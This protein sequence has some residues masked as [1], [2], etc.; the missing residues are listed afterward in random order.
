M[1]FEWDPVKDAANRA[2][3]AVGFDEAKKLFTSGADYVEIFDST[4]GAHEDGAH[5]DRWIAIGPISR[6]V[7]T[8]V[9]VEHDE[10]CV[11][12]ISARRATRREIETYTRHAKRGSQ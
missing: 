5:E 7:L 11:R 6:G 4:H 1:R 2:K 3:H 12:I 8:V 9:F 10:D